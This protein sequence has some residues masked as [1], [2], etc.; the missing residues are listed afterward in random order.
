MCDDVPIQNG[1]QQDECHQR[2][3]VRPWIFGTKL[4]RKKIPRRQFAAKVVYHH[5]ILH[6]NASGGRISKNERLVS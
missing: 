2:E 3:A 1:I 4:I 5:R 6:N